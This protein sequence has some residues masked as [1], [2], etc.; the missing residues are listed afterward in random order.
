MAPWR[1]SGKVTAP[2]SSLI[3]PNTYGVPVAFL[4]VPNAN[5]LVLEVDADV[6]VD[7]LASWKRSYE[8]INAT[9]RRKA[10]EGVWSWWKVVLF[11]INLRGLLIINT[12]YGG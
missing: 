1:A 2:V 5:E 3:I 11:F 4:G 10:D 7:K 8:V 12:A 6:D 9:K